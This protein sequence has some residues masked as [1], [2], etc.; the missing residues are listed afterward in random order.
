MPAPQQDLVYLHS[1]GH[2][3]DELRCKPPTLRQ[4]THVI[5]PD[6][7]SN[8]QTCMPTSRFVSRLCC[9][10]SWPDSQCIK[11]GARQAEGGFGGTVREVG[12]TTRYLPC[13]NPD[14]NSKPK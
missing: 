5:E 10:L 9:M 6:A 11:H 7:Y 2:Q 14:C 3:L 4:E 1:H 12:E 8:P 13:I